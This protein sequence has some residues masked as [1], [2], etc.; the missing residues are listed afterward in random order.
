MNYFAPEGEPL[1]ETP[2]FRRSNAF[3]ATAAECRTV[4]EAV[5][6]NEIHNFSK[7]RVEGPAAEAWLDHMMAAAW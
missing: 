2:T 5:G 3:A 1:E 4:R 7:Y 6:I